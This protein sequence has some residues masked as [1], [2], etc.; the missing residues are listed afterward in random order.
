MSIRLG[1]IMDPIQAINIKKDS[2]FA[3][4]LEAQ[5]RGWE[6]YYMEQQDLFLRNGIAYA[7]MRRLKVK[8]DLNG[9]YELREEEKLPLHHLQTI[10]MRKDPP[11]DKAYLYATQLLD[12]AE[13]QGVLV[14]NKP[15]S[16]RDV[17]EK[18]FI[19]W[20][21]QCCVDTLVT[22]NIKQ[23]KE[24]LQEVKDIIVKPLSGMAGTLVFRLQ[25]TDPNLNVI[26]E[27]ITQSGARQI[28]AQRYIP[29]IVNGD[30]RI[31]LI[32]G[33]PFLH[34]LARI[35]PKGETRANLAVGGKG[36]G[37]DLTARDQWICE[38]I[39]PALRARGLLFVGID[40]IGD[41]LSEINV[42]S[43]TCIRELDKIYQVNIAALL[44]DVIEKKL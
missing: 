1:I 44:L 30:K 27:T 38:Q 26:L 3:M 17:N 9:W 35:A 8:D 28:M 34:A 11:V 23:L 15:Q 2:S 43:P 40:V 24:F 36:I 21:P 22:S 19:A 4:L 7:T 10:L 33:K 12:L 6:I 42:T 39:A 14:V 25:K 13:Q 37:V 20:F 18:L 5:Q 31:L 32:D 41:Y 16:L 29:A